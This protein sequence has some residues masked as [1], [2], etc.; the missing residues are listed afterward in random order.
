MI[1]IIKN[2]VVSN[3]V[4]AVMAGETAYSYEANVKTATLRP[5]ASG[6][7]AD[8]FIGYDLESTKDVIAD[9][10]VPDSN[11]AIIADEGFYLRHAVPGKV[12]SRKELIFQDMMIIYER[13]NSII[14]DLE[15]EGE[16]SRI[17]AVL[18]HL[19]ENSIES[20][21]LKLDKNGPD[22][23]SDDK[24]I[25]FQVLYNRHKNIFSFV[26]IDNGDGI[27][28]KILR[29]WEFAHYTTTKHA[30]ST[31]TYGGIGEGIKWVFFN[32]LD[33]NWRLDIIS[34]N[35]VVG[36]DTAVYRF[37]LR[38]DGTR[39]VMEYQDMACAGTIFIISN[40]QG[41]AKP[42]KPNSYTDGLI[43]RLPV[44]GGIPHKVGRRKHYNNLDSSA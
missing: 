11:Q 21:L 17:S 43:E 13:I 32:A 23:I 8:I 33:L 1:K 44:S 16:K 34:K 18:S 12:S 19:V 41:I 15:I 28:F 5:V 29:L 40:I 9:T 26:L 36:G 20:V 4:I 6:Q 35:T 24:P 25:R 14:N 31:E 38:T 37:L 27:P 7:H 30:L 2:I 10:L 22:V 42:K 39:S 3:I